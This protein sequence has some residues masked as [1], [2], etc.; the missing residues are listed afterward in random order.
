MG[1]VVAV[2]STQGG[3]AKSLAVM[4]LAETLAA[5]KGRSVLVVDS[6]PHALVSLLLAGSKGWSELDSARRT[7]ADFLRRGIEHGRLPE[8][9]AHTLRGASKVHGAH[10]LTL[11]AGHP[12]TALIERDIAARD[13]SDAIRQQ[14]QQVLRHFVSV[15]RD[16]F[17]LVLIDC[18]STLTELTSG[19]LAVADG[20]LFPMQPNALAPRSLEV[21]RL[22]QQQARGSL[23]R[24]LGVLI[25]LS[26]PKV[27]GHMIWQRQLERD[28]SNNCFPVTVP[29]H[30]AL[31]DPLQGDSDPVAFACKYPGP[32][33]AAAG[34]VADVLLERLH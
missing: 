3:P 17:D 25:M 27:T 20:V 32:L 15:A 8:V 13:P 23:A 22:V 24:D 29:A 12:E 34:E 33:E 11:M 2:A 21:L 16:Q 14:Y 6:D 28:P 7:F 5:Q 1:R 4:L 31:L 30:G 18:P 10:S 9:D 19:W 26:H